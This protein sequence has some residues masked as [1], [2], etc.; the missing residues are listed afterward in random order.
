M[1]EAGVRCL[2][3]GLGVGV[4]VGDFSMLGCSLMDP[5]GDLSSILTCRLSSFVEEFGMFVS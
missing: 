5:L 2:L 3:A 1:G 4:G